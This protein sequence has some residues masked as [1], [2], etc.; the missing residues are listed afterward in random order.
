MQPERPTRGEWKCV[1]VLVALALA[2]RAG[3]VL[4]EQPGFYFE[5]S[6]DYDRAARNLLA[7][8]H[9]DAFYYRF[10]LYPLVMAVSYKM[11]GYGLTP[12]RL[13]Q[14]IF[15]ATTCLFVWVLGRR[16]FGIRAGLLAL[17]G[18]AVFPLHVVLAGIEYPIV[19]GMFLIWGVLMLLGGER[20]KEAR[21]SSRLVI[22]GIGVALASMLFEGGWVLG[23]F[24]VLWMLF[25]S[26]SLRAGLRSATILGIVALAVLSPWLYEMARSGDYRPLLL[27]PG[28]HLPAAPGVDAPLWKGSGTN[29]LMSKLS[30]LAR[31]PWWTVSHTWSEFLH[32]W[33][34]Y[35]DR[36]VS[37][38]PDFREKL[39]EKDARMSVDNSLVGSLS[40][41]LYAVGFSV[42][43]VMA[44]IGALL[45]LRTVAGTRVLVAWAVVLGICYAPFFTQMRYRIPADPT[46]I[47]LGACAVDLMF[48]KSLWADLLG[49][50]KAGWEWWKRVAEKIVA[51]QT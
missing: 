26:T 28:M 18:A 31:N 29:L 11:F 3:F 10:P 33:N 35:P 25:G 40:Q 16:H 6:L 37:A 15:G 8:G 21:R 4:F 9:F 36:L 20:P 5:D 23:L 51:R 50:L 47:L 7:T 24:V 45:T 14:A 1:M 43:L 46:F 49:S 34:P 22:A 32:F 44:A 38:D 42:L 48:K 12:L 13:I 27:R 41:S 30:G 19:I 39:H 2:L 17:F